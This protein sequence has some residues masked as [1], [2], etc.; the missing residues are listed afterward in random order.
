MTADRRG[1]GALIDGESAMRINV[2]DMPP[3]LRQQAPRPGDVY[4][5]QR[6]VL[7]VVVSIQPN[8]DVSLL[9]FNESGGIVGVQRYG[10]HYL[11]EKRRVGY[12]TNMPTSLSVDWSIE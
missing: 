11:R 1:D 2:D 6:G 10:V 4:R 5:N 7:M 9:M 8:G 3:E 12:V